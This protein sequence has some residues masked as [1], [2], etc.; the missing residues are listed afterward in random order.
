[1][2]KTSVDHPAQPATPLILLG[3]LKGYLKNPFAFWFS[4][5]IST[6]KLIKK[7]TKENPKYPKAFVSGA[8]SM[9]AAYMNLRKQLNKEQAL[10]LMSVTT[11]PLG[12]MQQISKYRCAEDKRTFENL[13]NYQKRLL[14]ESLGDFKMEVIEQNEKI[15]HYHIHSCKYNEVYTKLG[16]PELTSVICAVDNAFF[17]S[18]MPDKVKFHRMGVGNTIADGADYCTF[19]CVNSDS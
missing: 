2:I 15:Y 14:S 9:A 19:V 12:I 10:M 1:M 17:N 7:I 13:I 3:I 11:L 6:N 8:A 5:I 4:T 18:Y 16:I